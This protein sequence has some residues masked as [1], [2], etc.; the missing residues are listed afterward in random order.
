MAQDPEGE[1]TFSTGQLYAMAL[2]PLF[3]S[4]H[5]LVADV[6]ELDDVDISD[7]FLWATFVGNMELIKSFWE[8]CD[9]PLH[10]ALIGAYVSRHVAQTIDSVLS[11]GFITQ[12]DTL[13]AW[14]IGVLDCMPSMEVARPALLRR[15]GQK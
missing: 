1:I 11:T 3:E 9:Y 5:P 13:E 8:L 6:V 15:M 12:A 14:A 7:L 10:I 4:V 2:A